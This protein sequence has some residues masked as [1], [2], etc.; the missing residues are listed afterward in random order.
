[1]P[2]RAAFFLQALQAVTANVSKWVSAPST[3]HVQLDALI[4]AGSRRETFVFGP[5]DTQ[6]RQQQGDPEQLHSHPA[7]RVKQLHDVHLFTSL[8]ILTLI[9]ATDTTVQF[10]WEDK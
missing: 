2:F 1:M 6:Q 4:A 5:A 3:P 7:V 9:G 8:V 10:H